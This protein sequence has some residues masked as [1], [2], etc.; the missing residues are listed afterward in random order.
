MR[1]LLTVD[2]ELPVPP[3]KYGGIERIVDGLA[4][5]LRARGHAVALLA[6]PDSTCDVDALFPW[7]S[8]SSRGAGPSLANLRALSQAASAFEADL[9]HSFSR[10]LYLLPLLG[11]GVPRI[12]SYQRIPTRR[13][14][15]GSALLAGRSLT[16]TGCSDFICSLGRKGG[17]RWVRIH[18]FAPIQRY[19][20]VE[21]VAADAPLIFLG[22][23][24]RI[25]G[26]HTAIAVARR[27]GRRLIIAGNRPAGAEHERYWAAEIAPHLGRDVEYIGPVDDEQKNAL[28]GDCAALVAP[29][30]WDEPFGIVFVEALACGTPVIS[31]PRGALP[32][33]VRQGVDGFLAESI[34]ELTD[35]IGKLA[36]LDRRE[37]RRRAEEHFS[38]A[39]AAGEYEGLYRELVPAR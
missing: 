11:S 27:A 31:C 16:F 5:E 12:M 24:E 39:A 14:V 38:A 18:N 20:F 22:R 25:K 8:L 9:V 35:C 37:C 29:I 28:L 21:Q 2:P 26:A 1:V 3:G 32:E 30:E 19:T 6:H 10:L 23:V 15:R 34:D 13:T 17:G 4:V 36:W 7:P 33:I